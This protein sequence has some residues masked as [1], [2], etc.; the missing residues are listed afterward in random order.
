MATSEP[1]VIPYLESPPDEQPFSRLNEILE[2]IK[3]KLE[4]PISALA[5][6]QNLLEEA[7]RPP[8]EMETWMRLLRLQAYTKYYNVGTVL[9][10]TKEFSD[11]VVIP[12]MGRFPLD[13]SDRTL[14]GIDM[15]QKASRTTAAEWEEA[16]KEMNEFSD[17]ITTTLEKLRGVLDEGKGRGPVATVLM[18]TSLQAVNELL[19]VVKEACTILGKTSGYLRGIEKDIQSEKLI[20]LELQPGEIETMKKRWEA[21]SESMNTLDCIAFKDIVGMAIFLGSLRS[22]LS[23][24]I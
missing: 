20:G 19:G 16:E 14:G 23:G 17:G 21:F 3:N 12:F 18:E 13:K 5:E 11:K 9:E 24:L 15:A 8:P 2:V 4:Q 1:I 7:K 6:A 10:R 22:G